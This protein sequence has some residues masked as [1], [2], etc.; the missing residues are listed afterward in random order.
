[1]PVELAL[2]INGFSTIWKIFFPY[3]LA[4]KAIILQVW[5]VIPPLFLFK[6]L[7]FYYTL[8]TGTYWNSNKSKTRILLEIKI[9]QTVIRPLRAMENVM[10]SIWGAYDPP[11]D[12]RASY[13]EGKTILSTSFE[14]AGID[15]VPHLYVRIPANNRKLIESAI[16]SQYPEVEMIEVP[17]YTKQV[18]ADI[19]NKEWD[20]WGTDFEM[21]KPDCY[22]IKTYEQFFEEKPE[23][24]EEKRID[25]L[26]SL[27]ETISKM[28]KGEQLW[29]QIVAMPIS[30]KE[31][32]YFAGGRKEVN[33][34]VKRP[35]KLGLNALLVDFWH[36]LI[37]GE[38]PAEPKQ[39]EGMLFMPE[40]NLTGGERE[41]VS[42]IERK[43][44]KTSFICH[45]KYL[46]VAQRKVYDSGAKGF[47]VSFFAQFSTTHLNNLKPWS[48]TT[49]KIQSPDIFTARRLYVRKR[50]ILD[51]Y[52]RR[53]S[54]FD[55]WPG[56]T[57]IFNT[58]ELASMW[59]F[60]G[61]V[62][63]TTSLQRVEMKK[64]AP[65]AELPV[66]D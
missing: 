37:K 31:K 2:L 61:E 13:F 50:D 39:Q 60:P 58:E 48:G 35:E 63:P 21:V 10:S 47:G 1:M 45:I 14:I 5:W 28:S 51:K 64:G 16:Y 30:T 65:P 4:L 20:L 66:E 23:S 40:M 59:H 12:W 3:L 44:S 49:T 33:K 7:K 25:P 54:A 41:I 15:G 43:I 8:Y 18:P 36:L 26:S 22:P 55:P 19:P 9:P 56:G 29:I 62:V 17:D 6:Y 42:A 52:R 38:I 34:L 53:D 27:F 57:Y 11:K 46:Y 32:D 24:K